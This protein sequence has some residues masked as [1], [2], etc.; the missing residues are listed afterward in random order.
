M[1]AFGALSSAAT[2][3]VQPHLKIASFPGFR[4]FTVTDAA[5]DGAQDRVFQGGALRVDYEFNTGWLSANVSQVAIEAWQGATKAATLKTFAAAQM[6]DAVVPLAG[7]FW[8]LAAGVYQIRAKAQLS[9]GLTYQS[10]SRTIDVRGGSEVKG[11]Y[12]GETFSFSSLSGDAMIVHGAG[13]TDTLSFNLNP[14][15]VASINGMS[16]SSFSPTAGGQAIY[17]GS[18]VDYVRLT[19]GREIYFTGIEKLQFSYY[20]TLTKY[21][22]FSYFATQTV[23]LAVQP[24]DD[25]F[26]DQWNLHVTDTPNAW[27]FTKGSPHNV[28]L[29]SLDTGVLPDSSKVDPGSITDIGAWRL[30]TDS[31][32]DDNL[33]GSYGHGHKAIS[34]MA[35]TPKNSDFG[36]GINWYSKVYVTDVYN[37]VSLQTAIGDALAYAQATGRKVVFQGG[38][39][40]ENWLNNGGT[41]AQLESLISGASNYA[42][43]AIAAGNG[44]PG[45]NLNDLDYLT[46]VSGVARLQTNHGNVMSVGALQRTATIVAGMANASSVNLASYSNRGTN[47]TIVAPTDVLAT[48]FS[49]AASGNMSSFGG[50]SAANPNMAAI[51][52]LVWSANPNLTAGQVRSIITDTA[53]DLGAY[54]KDTTYGHG[55]A[56]ADAAVR[57]ARALYSDPTL[58]GSNYW[59]TPWFVVQ[60]T[61]VFASRANAAIS[62]PDVDT[63]QSIP[64]QTPHNGDFA[65]RGPEVA[66]QLAAMA[67]DALSS[68]AE[69]IADAL[70]WTVPV[71]EAH[72]P[73][74]LND[75][76]TALDEAM[77]SFAGD[78]GIDEGDLLAESLAELWS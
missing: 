46:S 45:G 62:T 9:N 17:Q 5:G 54:G 2:F 33:V 8:E 31:S 11:S 18:A 61:G 4:E 37:G 44:G 63:T 68:E 66:P 22:Y 23:N 32:D 51:A 48:T 30:I 69:D 35:S 76:F 36:A 12:Q 58:A 64:L 24:N 56:N 19:D 16:L 6:A 39:Q 67:V 77:A 21:P 20:T 41:Q 72:S 49:S 3:S 27:R 70:F 52:S 25:R 34:V 71:P 50:T 59:R 42:L 75:S 1:M 7:W 53:M 74:D 26:D 13:G 60:S 40:G 38:I 73:G 78:D 10:A 55:L 65:N 47:L 15:S 43:F 14:S 28:L 29:V 57:R